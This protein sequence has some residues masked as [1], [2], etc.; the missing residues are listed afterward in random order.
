MGQ[1]FS[2]PIGIPPGD[3]SGLNFRM[4]MPHPSLRPWIELYYSIHRDVDASEQRVFNLYPDGG[5]TLS[6]LLLHG[7]VAGVRLSVSKQLCR[8]SFPAPYHRLSIR[9]RAGGVFALLGISAEDLEQPLCEQ[10]LPELYGLL[11]ASAGRSVP[12]EPFSVLD[13]FFLDRASAT[14]PR[15]AI[16]PQWLDQFPESPSVLREALQRRGIQRRK[17]ERAFRLETGLSPGQLYRIL[18]VKRARSL[19]R[20]QLDMPLSDI[21]QACD[22]F[23]HPHF[24]R[25]FCR[26]TSQTPGQYRARKL[27]QIYKPHRSAVQ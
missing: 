15:R 1:R 7:E 11:H 19:L 10:D 21:A 17:L 18:R 20:S 23:D 16:V 6:F 27:S 3:L 25:E 22:Y 9:F 14:E 2:E 26:V 24:A 5:S 4:A 12:P 13:Q 8:T